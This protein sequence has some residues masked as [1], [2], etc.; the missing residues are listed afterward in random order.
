MAGKHPKGTNDAYGDRKKGGT[1]PE[2]HTP[3]EEAAQARRHSEG[4]G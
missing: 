4:E 2:Q 1:L 3:D